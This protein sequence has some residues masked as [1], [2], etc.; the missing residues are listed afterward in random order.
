MN[1]DFVITSNFFGN[2][3]I[4]NRDYIKKYGYFGKFEYKWGDEHIEFTKRYLHNTKYE[5]IY[6]K[7]H[8][9]KPYSCYIIKYNNK[10]TYNKI[11]QDKKELMIKSFN[12]VLNDLPVNSVLY[13][14]T[15]FTPFS[16][17]LEEL[18]KQR[19]YWCGS[20][21]YIYTKN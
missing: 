19:N 13:F 5:K 9:W 8:I 1:Y 18:T 3:L 15:T 6:E 11:Y 2:L 12:K 10:I 20:H 16:K 14:R 17:K 21:I 4:I 7:N